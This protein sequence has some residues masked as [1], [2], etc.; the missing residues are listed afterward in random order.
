MTLLSSH[1]A[2]AASL[3]PADRTIT[4]TPS[5]GQVSPSISTPA[6]SSVRPSAGNTQT[7]RSPFALN[8]TA[9]AAA[10]LATAVRALSCP[11]RLF[12]FN[13]MHSY[14]G[15]MRAGEMV[16]PLGAA[17]PTVSYHLRILQHAGLIRRRSDRG[18][19][20][21]SIDVPALT[22]LADLLAPQ[23]T[24]RSASVNSEAALDLTT[25]FSRAFTSRAATELATVLK[26][27][28]YPAR[29]VILSLIH[30]NGA[31]TEA[32]ITREI[33][34]AE[35]TIGHHVRTLETA[36]LIHGDPVGT[37]RWFTLN[38]PALAGLADVLRPAK[39]R[40]RA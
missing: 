28:A 29:L 34:V 13:L 12:M 38:E 19:S 23:P 32:K 26:A 20:W 4:A 2:A 35:T 15:E 39:R 5:P 27:L 37:S 3:S 17:Q 10:D 40:V 9:S 8:F 31:M 18:Y 7:L 22:G 25:P 33:D 24:S 6:T 11:S 30:S 1:P 14:A 16:K 36:K 21:S